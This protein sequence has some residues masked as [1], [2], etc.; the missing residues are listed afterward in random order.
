[1]GEIAL[2]KRN[3]LLMF[4]IS[5]CLIG[6]GTS[7]APTATPSPTESSNLSET[8]TPTSDPN[9]S[10][11][12]Y[13]EYPDVQDF[14]KTY[15]IEE[16]LEKEQLMNSVTS[17]NT[18]TKVYDLK[19][20]QSQYIENWKTSLTDNNFIL[21][22]HTASKDGD[23]YTYSPEDSSYTIVTSESDSTIDS[24]SI[25]FIISIVSRNLSD[26]L[27]D[28][29]D[30]NIATIISEQ[31]RKQNEADYLLVNDWIYGLT[32][33]DN[34]DPLFAKKRFDGSDYTKLSEFNARDLFIKD[35]FIYFSKR[36]GKN[37]G[38]YRMR[39][40]G[41]DCK[42]LI[43]INDPSMQVTSEYIYY[44][45]DTNASSED[46]N[47][48]TSH[49]FR[50][51]LDGTNNEEILSKPVYCWY[52]FDK[53][54]LY[55]DDRDGE[56]LHLF[57]LQTLDDSKLN[58][59]RSYNPIY[60]GEYIYYR[61]TNDSVEKGSLWKMKPDGS[62]NQII[63]SDILCSGSF[64][65]YENT[66]YFPN[67]EDSNRLYRVD[68]SGD[69]LTQISQ[70]KNAFSPYFSDDSLIYISYDDS[71]EYIDKAV[72]CDANGGNASNIELNS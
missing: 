67:A 56:S 38:I 39:T 46:I 10:I 61:S 14:G 68:T 60:D 64:C 53:G 34:G 71:L 47:D 59:Q 43:S 11:Y 51:Q 17:D 54:I 29:N 40:S 13:Q 3:I 8:L 55:Q 72:I 62:E 30:S 4:F 26:I 22:D 15:S 52:V 33:N 70:D 32:W 1:M 41:K 5:T 69:N 25:V 57:N 28:L 63:S 42:L 27:P 18:F 12:S 23:I 16:N 31:N 65:L 36:S 58:D 35:G 6:C 66:I 48:N 50:C 44:T 21:T 7:T 24:D 37:Q 9:T 45:P 49:L 20:D 2:M 19:K